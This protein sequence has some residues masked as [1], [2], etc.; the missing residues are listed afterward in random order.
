MK[1]F[2][3]PCLAGLALAG[4]AVG[5]AYQRPSVSAPAVFAE[6]GPWREARPGVIDAKAPWWQA[7]GDATLDEL[8]QRALEANQTLKQAE[9]QLR[10]AQALAQGAES[11]LWPQL[12]VS[13]QATRQRALALTGSSLYDTKAGTLQASWEP[14]FWGRIRAGRDAADAGSN[15][16]MA[17]LA[18]ARLALQA[19][20]VNSYAQL[21]VADTLHGTFE[22]TIAGYG[23][24]LQI[25][26]AQVRQGVATPADVELARSTLATAQAQAL[27]VDLQRSQLEHALAVLL[28]QAPAEFKLPATPLALQL[29]V[30]PPG[31]P[32]TLLERRPDVAGAEARVQV[33]NAQIGVARAAWFPRLTLS[34]NGGEMALGLWSAASHRVW[35]LGGALAATLFD[36]GARSAQNAQADAAFDQAA[37]S[38][39]QT[40]LVSFQEVEDN[41]AALRDLAR[42]RELQEQ[43][44]KAA[45]ESERVLLRQYKAGTANYVAVINAQALSLNAERTLV[46]TQGRELAASVALTKAT[47]GGYSQTTQKN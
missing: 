8:V 30:T 5:P 1:R 6:D 2:V 12:G 46:Q 16:S 15:A 45:R 40:V 7:Y 21:R 9:A 35:A 33:A 14:D 20:V 31:L 10:Q 41:L 23:K 32:S 18:A 44:L 4:C 29:P 38:Y 22:R 17:D 11:G 42:E 13:G 26:Q 25:A 3:I 47:G 43:A 19:A 36:A 27:D 24:S 39:R 28:G 37:A 34:A